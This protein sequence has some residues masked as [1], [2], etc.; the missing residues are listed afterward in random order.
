MA[1]PKMSWL[2]SLGIIPNMGCMRPLPLW[3]CMEDFVLLFVYAM[4]G[5]DNIVVRCGVHVI[6]P[7]P[8]CH[9]KTEVIGDD[10][11]RGCAVTQLGMV[12][13]LEDGVV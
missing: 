7:L 10:G 8:G 3:G 12:N 5:E 4:C 6:R 2:K 11:Q 13:C 9:C 1:T